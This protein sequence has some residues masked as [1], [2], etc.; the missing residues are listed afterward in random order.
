MTCQYDRIDHIEKTFTFKKYSR[1]MAF[2]NAVAGL[3]EAQIHHPRI[4][5]EWGKVSVAWGT[6]ESDQGSGILAKDKAMAARCDELYE[7]LQQPVM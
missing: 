1:A 4:V 5:I 2:C 7:L 6:H 3:A